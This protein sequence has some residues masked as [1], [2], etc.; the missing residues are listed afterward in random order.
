M[1][2]TDTVALWLLTPLAW[3]LLINGVDDLLVDFAYFGIRLSDRFRSAPQ[4]GPPPSKQPRIALMIPCWR[5]AP[6][7]RQM[8][9]RNLWEIDYRNYDVWVGV[10]PNDPQSMLEIE[11]CSDPR[12]HYVV[13][14]HNGPT[15]K[16]DCLNQIL[17][18]TVRH[19]GL[20]GKRYDLFIHHDA[21]DVIHPSEFVEAARLS[22]DY[23][24]IQFPVLALRTPV[25]N[26]T[27]GMYCDEFAESHRRDLFVRSRVGGFIPS[28]GVGTA[29][30]REV[31]NWLRISSGDEIFDPRSLTEDY[32]LGLKTF[33]LGFRQAFPTLSDANGLVATRSFFPRKA[34]AAI[35][36]RTRWL[37]GNILQSWQKFGWNVGAGQ[38]YWLWRDRKAMISHPASVLS[39]ALFFY[40][41]WRLIQS[42]ANEMPWLLGEAIV[43]DRTLLLLVALNAGLLFWRQL[44]KVFFTAR[45]Y[46]L[47]YG[48]AAPARTPW[49]NVINFAATLRA[50]WVFARAWSLKRP[51]QWSKT[52]HR[53]PTEKEAPST[54]PRPQAVPPSP[55]PL[56]KVG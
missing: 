31:V 7:I 54:R 39:N 49:A 50:V 44:M 20:T 48:L 10:Y 16:A 19:E 14:L 9:E 15:T 40:G 47:A 29:Y 32:F 37:I 52:A 53:F 22:R 42:K 23:D 43:A 4:S 55:G 18:G 11:Q 26:F 56:R 8:L 33:T 17:R 6:V 21:E 45:I 25:W 28:A 1:L 46:G 35:R 30:S 36:Q 27:H 34:A 2:W 5:E 3:W 38:G 12:V 24:M 41:L 51:L 13:N